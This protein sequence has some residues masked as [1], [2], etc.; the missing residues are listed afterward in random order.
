MT[1]K[2]RQTQKNVAKDIQIYTMI[3]KERTDKLRQTNVDNMGENRQ[4]QTKTNKSRQRQTNIDKHI[5]TV[6]KDSQRYT[7]TDND[8]R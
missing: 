1:D 6:K 5:Q 8:R 3:D 2:D 4:R 7:N